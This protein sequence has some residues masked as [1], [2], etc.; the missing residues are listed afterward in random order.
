MRAVVYDRYGPPDVLRPEEVERPV[1]KED[2][3]LVKIRATAV[4]RAEAGGLVVL[5]GLPDIHHRQ[6]RRRGHADTQQELFEALPSDRHALASSSLGA[7]L[8]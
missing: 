7:E 2:E 8:R 4:T 5:D 6:S 1:P 3:V